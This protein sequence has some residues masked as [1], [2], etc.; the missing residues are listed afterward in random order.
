MISSRSRLVAGLDSTRPVEAELALRRAR[1]RLDRVEQVAGVV[2]ELEAGEDA[3][4]EPAVAF[5]EQRHA[6]GAGPPAR[7]CELV[8]IVARLAAE[9]LDEL[10]GGLRHEM[11]RQRTRLAR[12]P[13]G[14]V[15]DRDADEEARRLDARLSG[16]AD[17]AAGAPLAGDG[18]DDV[19]RVVQRSGQLVEA[20]VG[21]GLTQRR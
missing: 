11:H 6:V 7:P 1:V 9:Q 2:A 20:L 13:V 17:Q 15:L 3:A 8:D 21:V 16:E 5:V 18:R 14:E 10:A 19:H 4:R 12:D